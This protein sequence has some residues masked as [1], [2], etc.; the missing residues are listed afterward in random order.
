MNKIKAFI[1]VM[2]DIFYVLL[3]E[4]MPDNLFQFFYKIRFYNITK[5][6]F[7]RY[8]IFMSKKLL[9]KSSIP[10]SKK[11]LDSSIEALN[12]YS[13]N[14]HRISIK[15][16][17]DNFLNTKMLSGKAKILI[18]YGWIDPFSAEGRTQGPQILF[19][20]MGLEQNGYDVHIIQLKKDDSVL[21]ID[22][23]DSQLVF[24]WS[25]SRFDPNMGAL[26]I[27][28]SKEIQTKE[29]FMIVGVI[30]AGPEEYSIDK[31]HQWAKILKKVLY[32]EEHSEYRQILSDIFYVIH[33][34]YI[35]LTSELIDHQTEFTATVH[36][37]CLLKLNRIAWLLVL[38]YICITLKIPY[39]IRLISNVLSY[40]NI[41]DTYIANELIAEER[42]RFGFGFIM[43]HRKPKLDAHLIGSFWDYYRLGVIPL[44]QMQKIKE[45]S[46]Y[47]TPYLDY[48]PIENDTDIFSILNISKYNPDHFGNLRLRILERMK[49]E[50][51]A[52]SVV[53]KI[54]MELNSG[55]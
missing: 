39:F 50:F 46:T 31:Y 35:Q 4:Y 20:K 12:N 21:S 14:M 18:P 34:P 43:V 29:N 24:I 53:N 52:K 13:K 30:T 28:G 23:F 26:K 44:V 47:L 45:I 40:K 8:P 15:F 41:R 5:K 9:S 22:A 42:M 11:I 3:I 2:R 48:F 51:S 27:F 33:T 49:N 1:F 10:V 6:K 38:R 55:N 54:L 17:D 25:L 36:V 7:Y 32:Y 37:S 19:L 16:R